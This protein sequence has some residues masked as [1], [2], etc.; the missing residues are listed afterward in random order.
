MKPLYMMHAKRW[1][2]RQ[3]EST[4][5]AVLIISPVIDITFQL[6]A[7]DITNPKKLMLGK[8]KCFLTEE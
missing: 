2:R 3:T 7:W 8:S 1:H 6:G 5:A 4:S